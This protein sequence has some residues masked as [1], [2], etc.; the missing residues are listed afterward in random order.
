MTIKRTAP[1]GFSL[2][3]LMVVITIIAILASISAPTYNAAIGRTRLIK[4]TS[5]AKS[6]LA[7][8][9]IFASDW[10]GSFPFV[11]DDANEF[12]TSTD[13]FQYMMQEGGIT[14]DEIFYVKGNPEKN[15]PANNDGELL[16]EENCLS[17]VTNQTDTS[18]STSPLISHEMTGVGT[19]GENHPYLTAKRAVVGYVGGHARI[20]KLTAPTD[21]ATIKGPPGSGIENIFEQGT[22]DEEGKISGGYLSVGTDN[23]LHPE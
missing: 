14:S 20:E 3:E 23:I 18:W 17:Y 7:G 5:H 10:E 6:I 19:F 11:D 8:M 15:L 1:K 16:P 12:S 22:I 9:R 21:G 13:A 2:L 4:D